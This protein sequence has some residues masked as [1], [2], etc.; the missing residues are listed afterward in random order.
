MGWTGSDDIPTDAEIRAAFA[1]VVSDTT[2]AVAAD[3]AQLAPVDTGALE[4][5][6][7]ATG[8]QGSGYGAAVGAM[9]ARNANVPAE[10]ELRLDDYDGDGVIIGAVDSAAPYAD[11]IHD[12]HFN[13]R[14]NRHIAGRPFLAN[15]MQGQKDGFESRQ[16]NALRKLGCKKVVK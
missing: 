11:L 12:G 8:P 3:A 10:P 2:R 14:A 5:S 16:A 6:L 4:A 13:V 7:Y 15:A 1:G 9:K